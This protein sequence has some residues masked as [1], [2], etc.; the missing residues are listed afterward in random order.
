MRAC[1]S[2]WRSGEV[3]KPAEYAFDQTALAVVTQIVT[4]QPLAATD[5]GDDWLDGLVRGQGIGFVGDQPRDRAGGDGQ[6]WPSRRHAHCPGRE[7]G[8][9]SPV[10]SGHRV[11]LGG[12]PAG[13]GRSLRR[14]PPFPPPAQRCALIVELSVA[15]VSDDPRRSGGRLEVEDFK[16]DPL[17]AKDQPTDWKRLAGIPDN[18]F[19]ALIMRVG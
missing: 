13:N 10:D 11:D 18:Q 2:G 4:D 19:G 6:H 3:L 5:R 12:A 7:A 15:T 17:L 1:R 16:P 14:T 9:G 8:P